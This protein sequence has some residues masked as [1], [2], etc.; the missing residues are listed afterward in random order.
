MFAITI[1]GNNSALP[2]HDRHPTSQL[3][4]V[5]DQ[6]FLIDCGEG[7]QVQMNRYKVRRSRISHIF[8]SHLHG[9]HY[10]GLFGLLNSLSLTGRTEPLDLFAPGPL[11]GILD[12]VFRVAD[13]TL[14]YTLHFH[15]LEQEGKLWE[16]NKLTV[17]CF[18]VFHRIDCWGF[19]FREKEK[20]RKVDIEQA[21]AYAIPASFYSK[22]KEGQD[23]QRQDGS[24]VENAMVTRPAP[25]PRSY[26][27]CADT[28]YRPSLCEHIKGVDLLY[29]ESTYLSDQ[30]SKAA[31]RFHSTAAQAA[32]IAQKAAVKTLLLGHFSSKYTDLDPFLSEAKLVFPNTELSVEGATYLIR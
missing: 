20:L 8:I 9:D 26:A 5:D 21:R 4:T 25:H 6:A 7:T 18:R 16:S 2:M 28:L 32:A 14:S 17:S 11:K 10:F 24:I 15:A 23:Y 19:L 1:L 27:F 3:V 30:E 22:L 29:H 12:D 31:A 13:T